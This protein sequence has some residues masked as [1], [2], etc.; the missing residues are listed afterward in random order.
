MSFRLTASCALLLTMMSVPAQAAFNCAGE[1]RG[2][3]QCYEHCAHATS[4][5]YINE[6]GE[7][8]PWFF[9]SYDA[10]ASFLRNTGAVCDGFG[11][12]NYRSCIQLKQRFETFCQYKDGK[13]VLKPQYRFPH[14]MPI[15]NR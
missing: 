4:F 15:I 12:Y 9:P 6:K 13:W 7:R 8:A 2:V 3:Q 1:N 10:K 11:T 14:T 5:W